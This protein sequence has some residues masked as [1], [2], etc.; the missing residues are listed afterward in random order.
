MIILPQQE[1]SIELNGGKLVDKWSNFM[2]IPHQQF[3]VPQRLHV[4][5]LPQSGN[6][7]HGY[8]G[9]GNP[10]PRSTMDK[11]TYASDTTAPTSANLSVARMLLAATGNKH[12]Y[13][14]VVVILVQ[15]FNG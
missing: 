10:G 12:G 8:F 14:L 15:D 3:L 1:T 2:L 5:V 6:S 11:T 4:I 9:G 13:F 7:T